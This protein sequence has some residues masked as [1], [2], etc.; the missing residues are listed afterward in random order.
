M[1]GGETNLHVLFEHAAGYAMFKIREFEEENMFMTEVEESVRD[2]SR[3]TAVTQLVSFAPFKAAHTALENL[4]SVSE[5]IL[6]DDL[7]TFLVTVGLK[8]LVLGVV[9]PKL[10]AAISE[11]FPKVR[12]KIGL[13]VQEITRGIRTHFYKILKSLSAEAG[14]TA[15]LGLGHAYSR[16]KV[17]FNVNRSDNMIIQGIALLDQ[18]DKDV[19]TF[20][21]R[22]R[23]WYSY[24]F[25]ELVKIVTDNYMYSRV[26][27]LIKNRKELDDSKLEELEEIIGDS[28]KAQAVIDAS[29]S[30]MGMDISPI[31]LINIESFASRVIKLAEYR[32]SLFNYLQSKMNSVAPNLTGLLGETVAAR[33]ISHAGSLTNLA[34]FPASTVQILGAEKALFR[35]LK[36]RGKTPKYGLLFHSTF[37]GR[38]ATANKG[39]I[40]RFLA[41]K[42]SIASRLDSFSEFPNS[43][44]GEKLREQ[45]EER[46][47]FYE[48]GDVP[49]K[50][51]DV[52]KEAIELSFNAN[53]MLTPKKEKKKKKKRRV[54]EVRE[55]K[56]M[57]AKMEWKCLLMLQL[58]EM[59]NLKRRKGRS[60]RWKKMLQM[61]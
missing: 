27:F 2:Y 8:K 5:G 38:A 57:R 29:K 34:K 1:A 47:K 46:L 60:P 12:V 14:S 54:L 49:R 9:E 39:R 48:S 41:N 55:V 25:P 43:I 16:S 4:N 20:S 6:P 15:Q 30:S 18:L 52:M 53:S 10:A 19:N 44:F 59:E 22:I 26:V 61:M 33:L 35:A 50:N 3:F 42:C 17:K 24:H 51:V 13:V 21:M 45:V 32:K 28:G 7:K 40:S 56:M 31:D 11:T 36:T 37:I 58:M 23:E